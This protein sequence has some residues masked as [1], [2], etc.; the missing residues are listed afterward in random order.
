MAK[1]DDGI[2]L[3]QALMAAFAVLVA[4]IIMV[5]LLAII[6]GRNSKKKV[7]VS[8]L[9]VTDAPAMPATSSTGVATGAERATTS[10]R[11]KALLNPR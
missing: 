11:V 5:L 2:N 9:K 1:E 4:V 3:S 10:M 8:P 7:V 6:M